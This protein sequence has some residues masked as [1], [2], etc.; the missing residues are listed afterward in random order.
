MVM[1]K[2]KKINEEPEKKRKSSYEREKRVA[3][4]AKV[5]VIHY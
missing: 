1:W 3:K 4:T 2:E 5:F